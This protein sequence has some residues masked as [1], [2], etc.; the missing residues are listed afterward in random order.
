MIKNDPN[1]IL[2]VV[3]NSSALDERYLKIILQALRTLDKKKFLVMFATVE[4][5]LQ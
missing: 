5:Q 3:M 1:E 4:R 2:F